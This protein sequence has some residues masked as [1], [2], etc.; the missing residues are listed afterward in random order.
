M[1]DMT[2][3]V[4]HVRSWWAGGTAPDEPLVAPGGG[5]AGAAL[6]S[7]IGRIRIE[8]KGPKMSPSA[9]HNNPYPSRDPARS[10]C[11]APLFL[12]PSCSIFKHAP[13]RA[14]IGIILEM[15]GVALVVVVVVAGE[16]A[17]LMA[18]SPKFRV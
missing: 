4:A 6:F 18:E 1:N 3:T 10:F 13:A 15:D 2:D 8:E 16:A 7:V 12:K 5:A 11:P 17:P 9:A 14:R